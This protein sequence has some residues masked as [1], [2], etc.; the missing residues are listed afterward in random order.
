MRGTTLR[1]AQKDTHA[2]AARSQRRRSEFG[3]QTPAGPYQSP[4]PQSTAQPHVSP[5]V[6]IS[7][8]GLVTLPPSPAFQTPLAY[9]HYGYSY[10]SPMYNGCSGYN[11]Y[12]N[13]QQYSPFSWFPNSPTYGIGY[14]TASS[15]LGQ[16]Y[17]M[18]GYQMNP[19]YGSSPSTLQSGFQ[20]VYAMVN[21]SSQGQDDRSGTPT[22]AGH[23]SG[24]ESLDSQ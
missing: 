4:A 24:F 14:N 17:N 3:A 12:Y 23:G 8:P 13:T 10:G 1:I 9:Q 19:T 2:A 15:P 20:P 6:C 18:Q 22:P 5:V 16:Q 7:Q 21:T 11:G